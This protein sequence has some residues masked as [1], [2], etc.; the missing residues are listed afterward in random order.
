MKMRYSRLQGN[1]SMDGLASEF[2]SGT[3]DSSL[4]D[5]RVHDEGGLDLSSRE[6]VARDVDNIVDTPLNPDVTVLVAG[7]TIT[8]VEVSGVWLGGP[9]QQLLSGE[10][11]MGELTRM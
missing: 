4:S 9:S 3:D 10:G 2:I 6:T 11:I 7:S 1:E 5:A 8:S